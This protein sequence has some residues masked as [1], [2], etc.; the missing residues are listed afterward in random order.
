METDVLRKHFD[1]L[2]QCTENQQLSKHLFDRYKNHYEEIF[3]YCIENHLD[4]FTY[5][6]A[7]RY[8]KEKC[9]S[10]K[11]FAVTE[12]TKI[13]YTVA[14]YFEDGCFTWKAV[15]FPQYPVCKDYES[16]MKEFRQELM[17][18]LSPGT[19]RG[20][21]VIVRQFLY[22]L[23]QSGTT[24]ATC[25]TTEN[26]LSFVRQEAP[27]HKSSMAK[28]LRTMKK[29]VCFL[30]S[31]SIVEL[32][33]DRFLE[34]AGR[35]RQKVLPCFTDDEIRLI[36]QQIDRSTDKGRRD[37]AIFLIS[38]RLGLRASDISKLKLPDIN[39]KEKTVRVV[40]KK[41][42]TAQELPLPADVGNA[43]ADYI[44][45]SR[46]KT[47]NPYIF[48]RVRRTPS[49]TPIDPTAF[50][51]YLREYME[52]A[53]MERT[54]WDGKT[55][56][57]LRRTAGTKMVTSGV[58]VSTVSQVLGHNSIESSKRYIS[59]DTRRLKECCLDLGDMHTRKEGL[60]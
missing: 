32:D 23:E 27:N 6:D 31:K 50:N 25:I 20:G 36:F 29:F 3:L 33:A 43:V 11:K 12:T 39:W 7:V 56:H 4:V 18:K 52:A 14:G 60:I 19:V 55:F 45:H 1:Y 51:I 22:F 30:R 40:Q 9:P 34:K 48:L 8:C 46:Y 28:L 2:I 21:M 44:I 16:L 49:N 59:L 10:R 5:Q 37:Y 54:G 42:K 38:L 57:A 35:C 17:K 41:T 15:T 24:D 53:G 26:I 47:D 58:P 13:A